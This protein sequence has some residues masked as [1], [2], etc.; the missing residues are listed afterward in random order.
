MQTRS[1]FVVESVQAK[2]AVDETGGGYASR[3]L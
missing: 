2:E 1:S 3:P